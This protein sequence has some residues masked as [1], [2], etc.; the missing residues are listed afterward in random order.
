[1]NI[2]IKYPALFRR[3]YLP[4]N[5]TC[6][7][8]GLQI[9]SGWL[10]II[11]DLCEKIQKLIDD[12]LIDKFEFECIKEKYGSL[13]IQGYPYHLLTHKLINQ[14]RYKASNTCESCT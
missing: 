10:P 11:D 9:G 1:M 8:W 7:C 6:M 3:Y 2:I 14:A 13:R 4:M 5:Q 12:H